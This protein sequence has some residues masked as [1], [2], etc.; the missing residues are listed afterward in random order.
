MTR[1]TVVVLVGPAGCG[2]S[3]YG[4]RRWGGDPGTFVHWEEP[5]D[6]EIFPECRRLVFMMNNDPPEGLA[7][8]ANVLIKCVGRGFIPHDK[9]DQMI[10]EG[11]SGELELV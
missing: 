8:R 5:V 3:A 2:K 4:Q 9:L 11:R 1:V 6:W 10:A 7:R